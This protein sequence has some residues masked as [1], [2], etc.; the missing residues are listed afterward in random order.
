MTFLKL[1]KD[2]QKNAGMYMFSNRACFGGVYITKDH[3]PNLRD[4]AGREGIIDNKASKLFREIVENILIEVA[5]RFI[6][7]SSNLREE[8]LD[9]IN[10][11]HAALKADEDRKKLLRKEQKRIKTSIQRDRLSLE[12]LRN[13]FY[14]ISQLLID[15]KNYSD[16][17]ELL[18]LKEH[19]DLLDGSLKNF[20]LG[21]VPRSLGSIEQDYRLYRDIEIDAKR[22]LKQINNSVYSV[23]EHLVVKD[24]F[25][26]AEKGLS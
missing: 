1:R 20:S 4:K 12:N 9:E 25:S 8:K 13:E 10:A 11:K 19:I 7:R 22:I 16:L 23:L 5:K 14:E 26:I 18:H 24:D 21:S 17:D 6:G 2:A 15:K 3:N